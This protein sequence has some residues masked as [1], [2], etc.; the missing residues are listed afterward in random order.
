MQKAFAYDL[1]LAIASATNLAPLFQM[2]RN[3][4]VPL[5]GYEPDQRLSDLK[6]ERIKFP[7]H[8]PGAFARGDFRTDSNGVAS[9]TL[10]ASLRVFHKK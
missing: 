3:H 4:R 7:T 6:H 10:G 9:S 2:V 1:P 8:S 5:F